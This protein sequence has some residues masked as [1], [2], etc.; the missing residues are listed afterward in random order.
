VISVQAQDLE[1]DVL[2]LAGGSPHNRLVLDEP[3][4]VLTGARFGSTLLRSI[5]DA[6]PEL[7]C[8]AE[9]N[10]AETLAK[11]A[12]AWRVMDPASAGNELSKY[13]KTAA[14]AMG[15]GLFT[16]YL[17]RQGKVRW[18]E[19]SL[20]TVKFADEFLN[21][22]PKAK[23]ICL[24]RHCM[25]VVYSG[26]EAS[27]WGLVGYGFD[28]YAPQHRGNNVSALTSYW[29]EHAALQAS[30][31]RK[32]PDSCHRVYY[33]ELV[34][35]PE[36]VSD[37]LLSFIGVDPDPEILRRCFSAVGNAIGPGD[38]KIRATSGVR[39]ESV[40]RGARVPIS[41]IPPAQLQVANGILRSLGYT[42]ID[43][44]WSR[45]ACPL[46][47]LRTGGRSYQG[48]RAEG[49]SATALARLDGVM[50]DRIAA[51]LPAA[52]QALDAVG[53]RGGGRFAFV[54]Y[55]AGG[56][57]QARAWGADSRSC[58]PVEVG[59]AERP[60]ADWFV[61]GEVDDWLDVLD[62]SLSVQLA[63][64]SGQLRYAQSAASGAAAPWLSLDALAS[65][66]IN[67]AGKLLG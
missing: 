33:E 47:L 58:Q 31:E 19:K 62:G 49:E 10:F 43:E 41:M 18:C 55:T 52:R 44:A 7:A 50:R 1:R 53:S 39:E 24:Y 56:A 42:E 46:P 12:H 38:F 60:D 37:E 4:I 67:F 35:D 13:A 14:R 28:E 11:L 15:A 9:T 26:L 66:R 30:F 63:L 40:G 29:M 23:F 16:P 54:A 65:A 22:Y 20:G 57:R 8:P 6:H 34:Q 3:V 32:H 21:I 51:N 2:A 17:L 64:K 25:D 61:T 45:A 48:G 27:P 59:S 5:L 36:R